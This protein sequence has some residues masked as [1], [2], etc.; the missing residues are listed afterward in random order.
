[1][2]SHD[3]RRPAEF[4][5]LRVALLGA[6]PSGEDISRDIADVA[7]TVSVPSGKMS[8]ASAP[9]HTLETAAVAQDSTASPSTGWLFPVGA[10]RITFRPAMAV[11]LISKVGYACASAFQGISGYLLMPHVLIGHTLECAGLPVRALL[12]DP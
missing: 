10:S 4:A 12:D 11:E 1:M 2:H 7:D 6:N 8:H 3:Y 9:K 5:G